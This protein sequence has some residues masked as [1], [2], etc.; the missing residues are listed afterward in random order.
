MRAIVNKQKQRRE[1]ARQ[2]QRQ[3]KEN[4]EL[5]KENLEAI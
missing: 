1:I 3:G 2:F 4:K 5:K